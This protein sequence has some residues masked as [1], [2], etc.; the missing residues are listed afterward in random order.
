[1]IFMEYIPV[2]ASTV[3]V[4]EMEVNEQRTKLRSTVGTKLLLEG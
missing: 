3:N 1:M 4:V 2:S